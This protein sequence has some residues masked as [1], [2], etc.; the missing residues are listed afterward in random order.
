MKLKSLTLFLVMIFTFSFY[1]CSNTQNP[2]GDSSSGLEPILVHLQDDLQYNVYRDP[3]LVGDELFLCVGEAD[4]MTDK[5]VD[6]NIVTKT[7][8][9]IFKS[10]MTE[11]VVSNTLANEKWVVW[12]ESDV[13]DAPN[14]MYALNRTTDE[15]VKIQEYGST[16]EIYITLPTLSENT[17]AWGEFGSDKKS[18][19]KMY[20]L[21]SGEFQTIAEMNEPGTYNLNV[22]IS[23]N[24]LLWTDHVNAHGYYY[25]YNI[26][27]KETKKIEAPYAYPGLPEMTDGLIYS[28]NFN[29]YHNWGDQD[30]GWFDTSDSTYH[31][32][33]I[34]E[35]DDLNLF[36]ISGR[37]LAVMDDQNKLHLIDLE[38][39]EE[40]ES[41]YPFETVDSIDVSEDG[42]II[43]GIYGSDAQQATLAIYKKC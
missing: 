41:N 14:T 20:D 5:V 37:T 30:F 31:P 8:K 1:G 19:V 7:T 40:L 22:F 38:N 6:Y 17:L 9:L 15:I 2:N 4:G 18:T 39:N 26:S 23:G 29:D 36:R 32:C 21:C 35:A 34:T 12:L 24:E 11:P 3:T 28:I 33:V 13:N 27:S 25:I 10:K 42:T 43:A 16:Q